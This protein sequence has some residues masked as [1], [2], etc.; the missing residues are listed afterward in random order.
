VKTFFY[1]K[2]L[3]LVVE[4]FTDDIS[5]HSAAVTHDIDLP[6]VHILKR[7]ERLES[8]FSDTVLTAQSS[9]AM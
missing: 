2:Q 4:V 1:E 9:D 8:K 6:S 5:R 7:T 3:L